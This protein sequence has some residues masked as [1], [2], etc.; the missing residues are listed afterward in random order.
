MTSSLSAGQARFVEEMSLFLDEGGLPRMAGRIL[1]WLLICV[2]EHQS[3]AEIGM[4]L[5][6]SKGSISTMTRLLMNVGLV[7]RLGVPGRRETFFRMK[8][9]VW[10]SLFADHARRAGVVRTLA[11]QGLDLLAHEEPEARQRLEEMHDL[12]AFMEREFP[13]LLARWEREREAQGSL[14]GAAG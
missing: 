6:A 3:A 13:A 10:S 11:E 2:P 14:A 9:G 1:G 4:A 12:H 7:E 8:P 5:P